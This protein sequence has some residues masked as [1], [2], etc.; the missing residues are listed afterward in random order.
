MEYSDHGEVEIVRPELMLSTD[1]IDFDHASCHT[2][3]VQR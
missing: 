3:P 1:E 2:S